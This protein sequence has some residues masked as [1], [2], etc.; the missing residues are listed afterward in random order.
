MS[1]LN[2]NRD[3]GNILAGGISLIIIVVVICTLVAVMCGLAI[4]FIIGILVGFVA[5]IIL[6][7]L[8]WL[9]NSKKDNEKERQKTESERVFNEKFNSIIEQVALPAKSDD[10]E[11]KVTPLIDTTAYK[12][13][14][15]PDEGLVNQ[16]QTPIYNYIEMMCGECGEFF[17]PSCFN[18]LIN[19]FTYPTT[20]KQRLLRELLKRDGVGENGLQKTIIV[21]EEFI[22]SQIN[23]KIPDAELCEVV[24]YGI[25]R[26]CIIKYF[27]DKYLSE[28]GYS[29]F[30]E[31]CDNTDCKPKENLLGFYYFLYENNSFSPLESSYKVF[32][33]K[34]KS[35]KDQSEKRAILSKLLDGDNSFK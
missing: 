17:N 10:E 19:C 29:T 9:I 23:N 20:N 5:F 32:I 26:Y 2:N 33:S 35:Y 16:F 7:V 1:D 34:I 6:N 13:V 18:K 12:K 31:Y 21:L 30:Q 8:Y 15:S 11:G 25:I 14:L 27:H 3:S 4:V 24:V 22:Y 28:I